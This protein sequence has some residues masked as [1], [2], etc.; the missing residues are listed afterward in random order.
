MKHDDDGY[1]TGRTYSK[2]D[3]LPCPR[4]YSLNIKNAPSINCAYY[5]KRYQCKKCGQFFRLDTRPPEDNLFDWKAK[6]G[7]KI[8][9]PAK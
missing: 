4:C 9:L 5:E 7:L 3:I 8:Q 6:E 2:D 1:F